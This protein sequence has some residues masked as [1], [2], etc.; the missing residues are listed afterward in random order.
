GTLIM[1]HPHVTYAK[2]IGRSVRQ[3]RLHYITF[4]AASILNNESAVRAEVAQDLS[5]NLQWNQKLLAP[6]RHEDVVV[7]VG[8][9]EIKAPVDVVIVSEADAGVVGCAEAKA[10]S[11]SSVVGEPPLH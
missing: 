9:I 6:F 2:R 1:Q 11:D 7:Y 10:R 5:F 3:I 4:V 8:Y